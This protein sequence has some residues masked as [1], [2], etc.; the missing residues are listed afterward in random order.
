M[1]IT[2]RIRKE[3]GTAIHFCKKND[4]NYSS[5]KVVVSGKQ[6][7][8]ACVNA[9]IEHGFIRKASD[10]P[11]YPDESVITTEKEKAGNQ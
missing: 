10:L 9:L 4:L 8:K 1:N 5:F 7:S 6:K 2:K 3:W 11:Q